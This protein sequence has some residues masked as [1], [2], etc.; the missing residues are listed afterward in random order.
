MARKSLAPWSELVIEGVIDQPINSNIS[1]SENL[2]PTVD[3]GFIDQQGIWKG[4]ISSD[5]NF[6]AMETQAGIANTGTIL[7]PAVTTP[8][9]PIDMTGYSDIFIAIK[10]SNGGNYAID[11]VMGPDSLSFANLSPVN[12]AATLRGSL[13]SRI[14]DHSFDQLLSDSQET[15]IVD[16]W[17][18][19]IV[20]QRLADQKLLQFKIVNNSGGESDIQTAFMRIV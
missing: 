18:I 13:P 3:T 1:A 9:W 8:P 17:N 7:A 15:L 4:N 11:A 5:T 12:A 2:R 20:Q 16:V 19:F 10:P 14:E 6:I